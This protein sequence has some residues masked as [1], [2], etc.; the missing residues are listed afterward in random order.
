[1]QHIN[2]NHVDH[3]VS[4]LLQIHTVAR[5]VS[6]WTSYVHLEGKLQIHTGVWQRFYTCRRKAWI[7][8]TSNPYGRETACRKETLWFF[9]PRTLNPCGHSPCSASE[10]LMGRSRILRYLTN[11]KSIGSCY[12]L[13][14][15]N[16]IL[17]VTS[18][19]KPIRSCDLLLQSR[20][21]VRRRL[22]SSNPFGSATLFL[23]CAL[24]RLPNNFF[25]PIRSWNMFRFAKQIE[26]R[27][28]DFKSVR[29]C[30]LFHTRG[31]A[32]WRS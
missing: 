9:D 21:K 7:P 5:R 10:R 27:L 23:Y 3:N 14:Q 32:I 22:C 20:G 12:L 31:F 29:S 13:L 1:V 8:N 15:K 18:S 11:F 16:I 30:N 6:T 4:V 28:A 2:E 19:F 25:K 17:V 26:K 24:G